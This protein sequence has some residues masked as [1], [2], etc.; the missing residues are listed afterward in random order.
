[1]IHLELDKLTINK[2]LDQGKERERELSDCSA[3][4]RLKSLFVR[5]FKNDSQSQHAEQIPQTAL[6]NFPELTATIKRLDRHSKKI[7]EILRTQTISTQLLIF[8]EIL[9]SSNETSFFGS[10]FEAMMNGEEIANILKGEF[11]EV[12]LE[13]MTDNFQK[14][15]FH[16][17]VILSM[18]D[19]VNIPTTIVEK[20]QVIGTDLE[21]TIKPNEKSWWLCKESEKRLRKAM[22]DDAVLLVNDCM[23]VKFVGK[24]T[25]LCTHTYSA[26]NGQVFIE[27]NWYSP[28]DDPLRDQIREAFDTGFSRLKINGEWLLIRPLTTLNNNN[29]VGSI[30]GALIQP[31]MRVKNRRYMER[32]KRYI[33]KLPDRFSQEIDGQSRYDYRTIKH[34]SN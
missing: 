20:I 8:F 2:P 21:I 3:G 12:L 19:K 5:V 9:L 22:A 31:L 18:A 23:L 11:F 13:A 27:G 14:Y 30:R 24:L 34:E 6:D 25:A 4:A 1:M 29:R 7:F 33:N 17:G 26:R 10:K 28:V 15:R 32:V 16:I